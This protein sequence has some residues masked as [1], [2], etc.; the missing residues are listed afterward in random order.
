M[1]GSLA[2]MQGVCS[3]VLL[4]QDSSGLFKHIVPP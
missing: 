3:Q 4:M 1:S 2:K